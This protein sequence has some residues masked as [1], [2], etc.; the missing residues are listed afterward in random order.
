MSLAIISELRYGRKELERGPNPVSPRVELTRQTHSAGR[1]SQRNGAHPL[2]ARSSVK[3]P[4]T[5]L[6]LVFDSSLQADHLFS[7]SYPVASDHV[8]I[9]IDL[10]HLT[11][12][13]PSLMAV[14][15]PINCIGS[16]WFDH[17]AI[18]FYTGRGMILSG[19]WLLSRATHGSVAFS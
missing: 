10:I 3:C 16:I 17:V 9:E 19:W 11:S 7:V 14:S 13:G 4:L 5:D 18:S 8:A 15:I 6:L 12:A 2:E 1:P